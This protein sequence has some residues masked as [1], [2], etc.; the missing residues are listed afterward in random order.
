[1]IL[2]T[3]LALPLAMAAEKPRIYVT[4]SQA[5]QVAGDASV[6][7]VKG[8]LSLMSGTSPQNVEVMKTFSQKCPGVV[9]TANRDKAD[10]VVR[11]DHE[12]PSPTTLFTHGNKVA[13]FD[14]SEDLIYSGSTRLLGNA[15]KSACEAITK[16]AR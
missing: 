4:E 12:E 11:L 2:A 10:F 8:S 5:V 1:M 6:A 3:A 9:I 14:K 7:D 13:V 15:V 16:A